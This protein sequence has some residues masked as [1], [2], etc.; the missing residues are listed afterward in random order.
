MERDRERER[1]RERV[2]E[3]KGERRGEEIGMGEEWRCE[4]REE[5]G[6]IEERKGERKLPL[7]GCVTTTPFAIMNFPLTLAF[8]WYFFFF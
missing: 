4:G 8:F 7:F 1:E 5:E 6:G 3:R 2:G